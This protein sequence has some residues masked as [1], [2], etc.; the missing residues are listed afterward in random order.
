[1]QMQDE[2]KK[3]IKRRQRLIQIWPF[4]ALTLAGMMAAFYIWAFIKQPVLVNPL[5]VVSLMQTGGLDSTTQALLAVTAPMLLLV[6]GALA[7]LLL[8]FVSVGLINEG[9][10]MRVLEKN[11]KN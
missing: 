4:I 8:L 11:M 9:R 1:M 6:V 2:M 7:L 3:V 5:H 10:L